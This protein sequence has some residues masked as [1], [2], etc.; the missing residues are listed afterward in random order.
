MQFEVCGHCGG[1]VPIRGNSC[2]N[3]GREPGAGDEPDRVVSLANLKG[4]A[5]SVHLILSYLLCAVGMFGCVQGLAHGASETLVIG[6]SAALAG[7][8]AFG[9]HF[10]SRFVPAEND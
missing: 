3:C 8:I 6:A 4:S 5:G 7:G 1:P 9:T 2:W 10:S